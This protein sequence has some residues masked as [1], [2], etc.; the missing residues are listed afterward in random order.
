MFHRLP[1]DYRSPIPYLITM[2]I[3]VAETFVM[4]TVLVCGYITLYGICILVIAFV[5]DLKQCM[6]VVDAKITQ[7]AGIQWSAKTNFE[8]KSAFHEI[9]QLHAD[10]LK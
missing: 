2:V 10:V 9:I 1:Y 6:C 8:V 5:D 7:N 3:E 4:A